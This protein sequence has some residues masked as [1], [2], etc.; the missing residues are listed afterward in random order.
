MEMECKMD[1]EELKSQ[2]KEFLG[3]A[4]DYIKEMRVSDIVVLKFC[5]LSLGLILGICLPKRWKRPVLYTSLFAFLV[6][7]LPLLTKW[8]MFLGKSYCHLKKEIEG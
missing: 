8:G 6:T 4:N 3:L 2:V 5:V 1:W 7:Y